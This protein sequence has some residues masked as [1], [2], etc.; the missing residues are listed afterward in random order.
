MDSGPHLD[1]GPEKFMDTD[2]WSKN[3]RALP[4][5]WINGIGVRFA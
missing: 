3:V 1:P 2:T 5:I 4:V